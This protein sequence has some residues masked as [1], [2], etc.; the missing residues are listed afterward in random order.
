MHVAAAAIEGPDG[1]LLITQR[2][3]DA[4]QGGLW[5]FPGGKLEPGESV[6]AALCR[7]LREELGIEALAYHPLIR[8]PYSYPDKCVLLDVWRVTRFRG[9]PRGLEGQPLRWVECEALEPGQF[10][11]A[12]R[13][14]IN[15][16]QL[17]DRYLVTGAAAGLKAFEQRLGR[18]LEKGVRLVQLRA[19]DLDPGDYLHYA[20][21]AR[22]LCQGVG[23]Q[24]LLNADP[25]LASCVPDVGLHLNSRRLM[26]VSRD[27]LEPWRGKLISASCHDL[28]ELMRAS[29]LALSFVSLSPVNATASHPGAAALGWSQFEALVERAALPVYALGG[30]DGEDIGRVQALG[31]QGVAAIRAFWE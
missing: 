14:I 1:R 23:A 19:P 21:R 15:A 18:A 3:P 4:H 30:V 8:I 2:A 5:E 6:Q 22:Q 10:P 24:L 16:L 11:A 20:Q 17:P 31:G 9:E 26:A 25:A 13:P 7:E 29:E 27:E 12:N 28:Q